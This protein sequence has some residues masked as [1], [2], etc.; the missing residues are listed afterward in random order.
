MK[1]R[2]KVPIPHLFQMQVQ[3][4]WEKTGAAL[5]ILLMETVSLLSRAVSRLGGSAAR[6]VLARE[7]LL[8]PRGAISGDMD[9]DR[10]EAL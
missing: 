2:G 8:C 5:G 10:L 1:N 7:G 9:Q 3:L 4:T 6:A